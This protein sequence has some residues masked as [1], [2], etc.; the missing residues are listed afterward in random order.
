MPYT[1]ACI[2]CDGTD[3]TAATKY[4]TATDPTAATKYAEATVEAYAKY[5]EDSFI[6]EAIASRLGLAFH[7]FTI[8]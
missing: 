7:A 5:P 8:L 6:L 1:Y 3:P 2:Y 4:G